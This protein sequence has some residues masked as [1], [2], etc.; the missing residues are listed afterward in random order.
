[1]KKIN[2]ILFLVCCFS[3]NMAISQETKTKF[4]IKVS[5]DRNR[6]ALESSNGCNF[7]SLF[8]KNNDFY[9]NQNGMV[10][11]EKNKDEMTT[12]NFIIRIIKKK[13]TLYFKSLKGT[14]WKE[15][16]F[17]FDAFSSATISENGIITK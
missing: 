15:E 13:N 2:K 12:S 14:N 8:V 16:T 4:E 11:I 17:S 9:L 1:M 6:I 10:D 5:I 7:N 3:L